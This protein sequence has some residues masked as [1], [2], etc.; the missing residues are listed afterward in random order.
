M[1]DK[2]DSMALAGQELRKGGLRRRED[3]LVAEQALRSEFYL[4]ILDTAGDGI[5]T[6][7]PD[8]TISS[9]NRGAERILGYTEEEVKGRRTGFL[10]SVD[11]LISEDS[12]LAGYQPHW[13]GVQQH[14]DGTSVEVSI[15]ASTVM[16]DGCS[17]MGVVWIVRDIGQQRYAARLAHTDPLTGVANRRRLQQVLDSEIGRAHRSGGKL[18]VT[19]A[20]LD[21]L[22]SINDR[23]GHAAGDA[24]LLGFT[25]LIQT[26][27]RACDLLARYGGDEFVIVMPDAWA[28]DAMVCA[29][30]MC[31]VIA[32]ARFEALPDGFTSSFG[33]AEHRD[34]DDVDAILRRADQAL[35]LAKSSGRNRARQWTDEP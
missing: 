22:K 18:S 16:D 17:P 11:A 30:R 2:P 33:I 19:I 25:H 24:A 5:I 13:E 14:K 27:L 23:Y 29:N 12:R 1:M 4:A 6:L 10:M 15:D 35:Y 26:Q 31:A 7:L 8:G 9:W 20:D 21:N 3:R 32:E 28:A 34:V